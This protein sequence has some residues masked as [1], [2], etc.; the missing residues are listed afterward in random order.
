M[1]LIDRKTRPESWAFAAVLMVLAFVVMPTAEAQEAASAPY[2]S[3]GTIEVKHDRF[4]ELIPTDSRL[5]ILASGFEWTE[6]PVWWPEQ[7]TVLFSDIPRNTV[8]AWT[9]KG[10]LKPFLKPSGYTGSDQFTGQ[11]PGS[12]GLLFDSNG[13]LILC[14]HGDRRVA[15]LKDDR[16]FETLASTYQGKRLNSP[17]DA[18]FKSDGSLYF[19]DP[20]YGLPKNVDDPAKELPFQGVYRLS[21]DGT[22]TLLTDQMTRPNGIAFS[23]DESILY[24]ANSDPE[25]A[26]W[27]AFPLKDD[28]TL[29]EG[30]VFA[31]ATDQVGKE[32][33][34][35][36]GMTVDRD[37]NLFATGPGGVLIF[38][39][40]GTHLGTLKTGEATANCTFGGEDGSVLYVTADMHFCRIPTTTKGLGFND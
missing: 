34:L 25:K 31:D 18:V 27:M 5:E 15:R 26:I 4:R 3:L 29:G 17:N 11:E 13:R 37:G 22:L 7:E 9:K 10:E 24:V 40:D 6:G 2:D 12:N 20:P 21:P 36:D 28:G 33:G 16:T 32:K 23:P 38:A 35:P 30:K 19:T 1:T 14:Q 8:F 39:P